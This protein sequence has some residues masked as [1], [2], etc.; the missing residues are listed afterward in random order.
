VESLDCKEIRM[1]RSSALIGVLTATMSVGLSSCDEAGGSLA[2][3][4]SAYVGTFDGDLAGDLLGYV[5]FDGAFEAIFIQA[6]GTVMTGGGG[7][8]TTG[9]LQP[10][11]TG[12]WIEG[13][14]DL[15]SCSGS[16]SWIA[17][18]GS[19]FEKIGT[20]DMAIRSP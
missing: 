2:S 11:T 3:C 20:F 19:N 5:R 13:S 16:G 14:I 12:L 17:D 9:E 6:S 15:E 4:S 18:R 10:T 1:G 8:S 7:I